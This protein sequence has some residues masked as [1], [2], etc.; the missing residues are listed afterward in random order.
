[1]TGAWWTAEYRHHREDPLWTGKW[2]RASAIWTS[3]H[4]AERDARALQEAFPFADVR[5]VKVK[6]T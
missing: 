2:V 6:S 5:T 3:K 4:Q 1:M